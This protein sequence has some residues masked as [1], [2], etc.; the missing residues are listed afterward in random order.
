M[1]HFLLSS[2]SSSSSELSWLH[3]AECQCLSGCPRILAI[4][5]YGE[6]RGSYARTIPSWVPC[7]C[8][9]QCMRR[10]HDLSFQGFPGTLEHTTGLS[11]PGGG[12]HI[13]LVGLVNFCR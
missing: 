9:P 10:Y 5:Y 11:T 3:R 7:R 13:F 1:S 4:V 8:G 6:G 2:S 12:V